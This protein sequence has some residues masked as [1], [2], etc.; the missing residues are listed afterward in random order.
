VGLNRNFLWL[1]ML[2]AVALFAAGCGGINAGGTVS[3]AMFLMKTG[4]PATTGVPMLA[5]EPSKQFAQAR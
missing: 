1:A 4:P 2:T 3:P 5:P